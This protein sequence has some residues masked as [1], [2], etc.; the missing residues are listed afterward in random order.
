MWRPSHCRRRCYRRRLH[1][2]GGLRHHR[3]ASSPRQHHH[4]RLA[5]ADARVTGGARSEAASDAGRLC[6]HTLARMRRL[7]V[8]FDH[9]RA[10]SSLRKAVARTESSCV[11]AATRP[12][13]RCSRYP[14]VPLRSRFVVGSSSNHT[15]T[16]IKV[17]PASATRLFC[18]ADN[19]RIGRSLQVLA[20]TRSSAISISARETCQRIPIQ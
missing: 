13:S 7:H 6:H 8:L 5:I 15:G 12:R 18:P 3:T 16:V 4:R 9:P 10:S 14:R 11:V 20:P 1:H 17:S 2:R 19:V